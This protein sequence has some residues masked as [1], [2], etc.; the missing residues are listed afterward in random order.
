MLSLVGLCKF[1][2]EIDCYML[3]LYGNVD[4]SQTAENFLDCQ[5]NERG[6]L[7]AS[8]QVKG[9]SKYYQAMEYG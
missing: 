6:G 9:W 5:S 3:Y 7:T 1:P 4:L 2:Q 8:K